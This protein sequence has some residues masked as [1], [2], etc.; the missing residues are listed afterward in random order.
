MKDFYEKYGMS[1]IGVVTLIICGVFVVLFGKGFWST[2]SVGILI[3]FGC[4][5]LDHPDKL[6]E[7]IG[8]IATSIRNAFMNIIDAIGSF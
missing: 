7:T 1:G 6:G 8:K 3:C 5:M 2:M 4:F